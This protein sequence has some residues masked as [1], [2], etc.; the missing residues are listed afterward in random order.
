MSR[1]RQPLK[2]RRQL[3]SILPNSGHSS[4]RAQRNRSSLGTVRT[5]LRR[6]DGGEEENTATTERGFRVRLVGLLIDCC[7][8][9]DRRH[10]TDTHRSLTGLPMEE[11]EVEENDAEEEGETVERCCRL[12][13]PLVG[14]ASMYDGRSTGDTH[15]SP[16]DGGE[17]ADEEEEEETGNC[18]CRL[19]GPLVGCAKMYDNRFLEDAIHNPIARLVV[20]EEVDDEE[21]AGAEAEVS[22]RRWRLSAPSVGRVVL[23]EDRSTEDTIRNPIAR[24][25][26]REEVDDDE[27][28]EDEVSERR[29]RLSDPS[30]GRVGL[31]EDRPTEDAIRS[32]AMLLVVREEVD[33]EEE[34]GEEGEEE[35]TDERCCS[36]RDLLS[37]IPSIREHRLSAVCR[38][39]LL[40]AAGGEVDAEGDEA[41]RKTDERSCR[42]ERLS[43]DPETTRRLIDPSLVCAGRPTVTPTRPLVG[44]SDDDET[45]ARQMAA[46]FLL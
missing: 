41:K 27:E 19:S 14:R 30:I 13:G 39:L 16:I 6:I 7:S 12:F 15:H 44:L 46:P 20:R 37:E 36:S 1:Q 32:L 42:P 35:K 10:P 24:P 18:C 43:P 29:W 5:S 3:G 8:M 45:I 28:E 11:E 21:E 34:D 17:E 22:E 2:K 38:R 31:C 23:R 25:V 4:E 40:V 33:D 9:C 26:V